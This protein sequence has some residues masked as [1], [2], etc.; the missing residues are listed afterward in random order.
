MAGIGVESRYRSLFSY[1]SLM[2]AA[3]GTPR[4]EKPELWVGTAD[5]ATPHL[6]PGG[7]QA[8]ALHFV[9]PSSTIGLQSGTFHRWI[10][11]IIGYRMHIFVPM[12]VKRSRRYRLLT[13]PNFLVPYGQY[14][15]TRMV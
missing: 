13:E 12:T 10:A 5:S 15:P 14:P 2:P 4:D 11:G 1:Q 7:G 8:P 9:V 6:D 3:A